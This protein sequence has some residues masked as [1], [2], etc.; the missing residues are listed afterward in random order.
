MLAVQVGLHYPSDLAQFLHEV[1]LGVQP[2]GGIDQYGVVTARLGGC[3]IRQRPP[4][5]GRPR[6]DGG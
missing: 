6:T 2:A 3:Q 5:P 1:D 4:P